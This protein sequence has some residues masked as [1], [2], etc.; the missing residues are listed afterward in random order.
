[1]APRELYHRLRLTRLNVPKPP[2]KWV[3]GIKHG[4]GVSQEEAISLW[5]ELPVT[6][7]VNGFSDTQLD[8]LEKNLSNQDSGIEI[9]QL[10]RPNTVCEKH[11]RILK[12]SQ[13]Q[14]CQEPACG[15]CVSIHP[16]KYCY[17]CNASAQRSRSFRFIRVVALLL[18]AATAWFIT[19]GS[20]F[21]MKQ[22]NR[23]VYVNIHP[24][25]GESLSQESS[26]IKYL[27]ETDFETIDQFF[28]K[29]ARN[30]DLDLSTPIKTRIAPEL[31]SMPP[32]FEQENTSIIHII[33]WSLKFRLWAFNQLRTTPAPPA[34]IDVF[35]IYHSSDRFAV[36]P[37]SIGLAEGSLAMVHAFASADATLSNNVVIA[38]EILHIF[39][40]TDKYTPDGLPIFPDGYADPERVPKYPQTSA[41]LM[42][43]RIP[44]RVD[45]ARIPNSLGDCIIGPT[46]AR[47]ISW[48][49]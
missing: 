32:S 37:H 42:G 20:I 39:G 41:E 38:H 30:Y 47:E 28:A 35:V 18:L 46:T 23:T 45:R 16:K 11:R 8:K 12:S 10:T 4:L 19:Y 3:F 44:I 22:W 31:K 6:L 15:F 24:I 9:E 29:E 2:K 17:K 5:T 34:D 13:C 49:P 7:E 36:L 27:D 25:A 33:F 21:R 1:M 48:A 26:Y 14:K 43:G 40:A